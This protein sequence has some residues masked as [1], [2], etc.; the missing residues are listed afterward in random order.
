ML[1]GF[2]MK[3]LKLSK[4]LINWSPF[5]IQVCPP[6]QILGNGMIN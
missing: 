6:V 2:S 5:L 3:A 4:Q 1:L